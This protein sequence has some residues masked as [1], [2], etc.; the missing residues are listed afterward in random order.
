MVQ[1][2]SYLYFL[3]HSTA[4]IYLIMCTL[5]LSFWCRLVNVY[6]KRYLLADYSKTFTEQLRDADI[7]INS[8]SQLNSYYKFSHQDNQ[9]YSALIFSQVVRFMAHISLFHK[10]ITHFKEITCQTKSV[11]G[12]EFSNWIL[13]KKAH[14]NFYL[15]NV[16]GML[17]IL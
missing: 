9:E 1:H 7:K 4:N 15:S 3:Y 2:I 8:E 12:K 11:S 16:V 5:M 13:T 10:S 17:N 14:D 6:P